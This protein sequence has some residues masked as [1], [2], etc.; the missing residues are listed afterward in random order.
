[1]YPALACVVQ[2]G[3]LNNAPETTVRERIV[4]EIRRFKPAA[5]FTWSP[6]LD[7]FQYQVPLREPASLC[8]V[9]GECAGRVFA[10]HWSNVSL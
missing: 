7:F 10:S 3:F 2:D 1:M 5:V 8:G 9:C 4:G 6:Y